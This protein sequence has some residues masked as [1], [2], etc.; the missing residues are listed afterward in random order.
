M[1]LS[2]DIYDLEKF[3]TFDLINKTADEVSNPV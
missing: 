1:N 3:I 2:D